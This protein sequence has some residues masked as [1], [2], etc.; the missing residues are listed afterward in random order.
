MDVPLLPR[1][2]IGPFRLGASLDETQSIAEDIEGARVERVTAS[3]GGEIRLLVRLPLFEYTIASTR[4]DVVS[5]VAVSRF[6]DETADVHVLLGETDVFRTPSDDLDE[7]LRARYTVTEEF[8]FEV[9]ELAMIFA[10]HSSHEYPEDEEG[11]PLYYDY[12]L[13]GDG[14]HPAFRA[15]RP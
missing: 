10:N 13:V 6:I 12:V 3:R 2:G 4:G 15:G 14:E 11:F 1:E 7:I 9:Q 8:A 5:S